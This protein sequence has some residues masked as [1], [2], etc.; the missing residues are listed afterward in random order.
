LYMCVAENK[1]LFLMTMT[2]L[3]LSQPGQNGLKVLAW[4]AFFTYKWCM[5]GLDFLVHLNLPR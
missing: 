5:S 4:Y 3:L 1:L 2:T